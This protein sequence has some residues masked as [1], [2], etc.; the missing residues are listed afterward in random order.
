MRK[1]IF[2]AMA[3]SLAFA[4]LASAGPVMAASV[5]SC[6]SDQIELSNGQ[7]VSRIEYNADT[8]AMQL[9]QR[10]YNVDQVEDWG[11]CIKAFVD[12]AGGGSHIAFFDPDTLQPLSR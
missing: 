1:P 10:G 4:G 6:R 8:I 5:A 2:A 12:D 7:M 11:G 9:R 3:L